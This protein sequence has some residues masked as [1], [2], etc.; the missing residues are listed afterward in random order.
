VPAVENPWQ[1][2]KE[3]IYL[4][5]ASDDAAYDPLREE[6]ALNGDAG[7]SYLLLLFNAWLSLKTGYPPH[8]VRTMTGTVLWGLSEPDSEAWLTIRKTP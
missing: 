7:P 5:A 1:L 3:E 8:L 4:F 2:V 6:L